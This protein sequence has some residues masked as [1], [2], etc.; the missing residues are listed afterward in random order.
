MIH[1]VEHGKEVCVIGDCGILRVGN[2][3]LVISCLIM[4][5]RL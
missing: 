1:S 3:Y 4:Y 2:N 5:T